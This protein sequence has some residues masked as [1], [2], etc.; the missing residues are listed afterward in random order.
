MIS[1]ERDKSRVARA[2]NKK[3]KLKTFQVGDLVWK[4][5]LQSVRKTENS[6]SGLQVGKVLLELQELFPEIHIW[7]NQYKGHCYLELS[8]AN[9]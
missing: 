4:V 6:V 7:W 3:V 8:M 1:I 5:I 2:Y 9:I